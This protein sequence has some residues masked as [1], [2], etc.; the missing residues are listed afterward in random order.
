MQRRVAGRLAR[1]IA[2]LS[3]PDA[4][5]I[6]EIGCGTG[7][8][9]GGL[10]RRL[11]GA[12]CLFTDLSPAMTRRCRGKIGKSQG[13]FAVMDGELPAVAPVFDLVASSF[14]FQWFLDLRAAIAGLAAGLRPGG[15]LVFATLGSESLAEWRA[16]QQE[17]G[18]VPA[19]LAL[20]TGSELLEIGESTGRLRGAVAEEKIRL[21]YADAGA[22]LHEL[23]SLGAGIPG[24]GEITTASGPLVISSSTLAASLRTTSIPRS[25]TSSSSCTRL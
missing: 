7:F 19:G 18:A 17:A 20:P 4:P 5:R 9:S 6:L 15:R 1:R 3:L 2:D 12:E 10:R 16:L 21:R 8:L 24:P 22:F 11:P 13:H 23:K 25:P 14:A